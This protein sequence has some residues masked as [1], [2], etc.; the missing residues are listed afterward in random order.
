MLC[1]CVV[2]GGD[3][4]RPWLSNG[5]CGGESVGGGGVSLDRKGATTHQWR[6]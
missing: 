6:T 1:L 3:D 5:P 4:A 2:D